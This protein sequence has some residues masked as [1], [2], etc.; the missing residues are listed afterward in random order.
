MSLSRTRRIATAQRT[1]RE[2]EEYEPRYRR[3]L[4][5]EGLSGA[6]LDKMMNWYKGIIETQRKYVRDLEES[7]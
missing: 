3:T 5:E 4:E 1:L 6:D 2:F 7:K